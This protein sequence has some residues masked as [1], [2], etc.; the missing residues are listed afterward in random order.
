MAEVKVKFTMKE[1]TKDLDLE[2]AEDETQA[3][4]ELNNDPELWSDEVMDEVEMEIV[5]G[6]YDDPEPEDVSETEPEE[7]P[8]EEEEEEGS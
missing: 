8:A 5:S 1:F 6:S 2:H 4:A 7:E 3:L